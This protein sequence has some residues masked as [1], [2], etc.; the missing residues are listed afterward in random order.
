M[1]HAGGVRGLETGRDA[2]RDLHHALD[3]QLVLAADDR[4]QL[5]ALD[6]RHGDEL[7]A[8]DLA[9]VV[10]AHDVLVR[11]LAREQQF[12]LEAA[13]QHGGRRGVRRHLRPDDLDRHDHAELGVPRLVHGPHAADAQETNDVVARAKRLPRGE[14]TCR[15]IVVRRR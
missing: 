6:E 4:R 14:W 7:D 9:E 8:V 3:R 15:R 1:D 5:L 11:H 10:D 12:L 2:A 13:L